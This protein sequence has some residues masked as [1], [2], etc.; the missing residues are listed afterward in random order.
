MTI[1]EEALVQNVV[2]SKNAASL[3]KQLGSLMMLFRVSNI[4]IN[5]NYDNPTDFDQY[6]IFFYDSNHNEIESNEAIDS[7]A[8]PLLKYFGIPALENSDAQE[9]SMGSIGFKLDEKSKLKCTIEYTKETSDSNGYESTLG[10]M[11]KEGDISQE[12]H[13]ILQ[14]FLKRNLITKAIISYS[15]G[16]DSGCFDKAEY[17][18][19]NDQKIDI[20][21]DEMFCNVLEDFTLNHFDISFNGSTSTSGEITLLFDEQENDY[22]VS[23][24]K[25]EQDSESEEDDVEL[26]NYII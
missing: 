10:Q 15:G 5:S 17:C 18:R 14:A 11:V 22:S 6:D 3:L 1:T 26:P 4:C 8:V 12:K 23:I 2:T 20:K 19:K 9:F 7:L 21:T 24:T 16:G 25:E 13:A